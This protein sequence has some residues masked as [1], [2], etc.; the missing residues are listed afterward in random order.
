M[1]SCVCS[2]QVESR[3]RELGAISVIQSRSRREEVPANVASEAL[4]QLDE[5][6]KGMKRIGV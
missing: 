1:R 3:L 6:E 2:F 4:A 5:A